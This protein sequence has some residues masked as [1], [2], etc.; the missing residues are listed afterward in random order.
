MLAVENPD[1]ESVMLP[2]PNGT[3]TN[4]AS[5]TNLGVLY[6]NIKNIL[7]FLPSMET[8]TSRNILPPLLAL[9]NIDDSLDHTELLQTVP[10]TRASTVG[11]AMPR[12]CPN[13]VMELEPV[14]GI[15]KLVAT[16]VTFA[17]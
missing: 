12:P 7:S 2:P 4:G 10:P 13:M 6:E 14:V 17:A 16:L 8:K 11:K 1:P 9:Q 3:P 5:A 15:F